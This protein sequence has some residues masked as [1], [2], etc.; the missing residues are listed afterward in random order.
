MREVP[1]TSE[2]SIFA[3]GGLFG[4][5]ISLEIRFHTSFFL[6]DY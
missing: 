2:D 5:N 6:T 1:H 3:A 4:E